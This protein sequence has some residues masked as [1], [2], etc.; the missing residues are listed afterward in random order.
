MITQSDFFFFFKAEDLKS[1]IVGSNPTKSTKGK[2]DVIDYCL[3]F[4]G[5][6]LLIID[7]WGGY[8]KLEND[9]PSFIYSVL[10]NG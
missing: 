6:S 5:Y 3:N 7:Y 10:F 2:L 8:Y 1:F 4:T 9:T